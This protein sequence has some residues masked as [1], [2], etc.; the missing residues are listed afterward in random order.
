M[1]DVDGLVFT[2]EPASNSVKITPDYNILG[3]TNPNE[4]VS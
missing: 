1:F 3:A 2:N 4:K